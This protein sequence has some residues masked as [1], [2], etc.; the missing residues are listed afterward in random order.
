MRQLCASVERHT[1]RK[2]GRTGNYD[3][4][5][6][7]EELNRVPQD[8]RNKWD[9]VSYKKMKKGPFTAEEDALIVQTEADWGDRVGLWTTL[10]VETAVQESAY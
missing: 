5:A 6:I 10:E 3:W 1:G 7:S 4:T 2:D 9:S 8:C